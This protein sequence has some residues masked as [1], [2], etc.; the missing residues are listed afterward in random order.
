MAEDTSNHLVYWMQLDLVHK[1]YL[2]QIRHWDNL[3]IAADEQ[4]IWVKDFTV[5]QLESIAL[6]SIPFTHLYYCKDNL[7][8]PN[9]SLL[10]VGKQ[11]A[12]LW[13]PIE[14]A[15]PVT[16]QGFNHNFFGIQQQQ[17]L[18]LAPIEEEQKVTVLLA[19]VQDAGN[20]I[21]NAPAIR[22]QQLKW[23]FINNKDA[24]IIGEPVLP[25]N[26]RSYWQKGRFIFPVGYAFEFTVLEK[27]AA[28]QIDSTGTYLIWWI[29]GASYCLLHPDVLQPLSIASW[30][31]T[32]SNSPHKI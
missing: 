16:L 7:L 14:R 18:R 17:A 19:T 31:Q 8:F 5:S 22:L 20:Y 1:D 29:D 27:I 3:K 4:S 26:G 12:F 28:Q 2:A 32:I 10:P 30:R 6:K 9:S 25:V 11:P 21:L 24:L 23:I 13:T 15:L